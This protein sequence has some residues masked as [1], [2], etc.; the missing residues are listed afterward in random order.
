MQDIGEIVV[1]RKDGTVVE[2]DAK[3]EKWTTRIVN[4]WDQNKEIVMIVVPPAIGLLTLG[5]KTFGKRI[6]LQKEQNLKDRY[7][8][9][10]SLGHYWE[11]KKKLS[12]SQWTEIE[13]RKKTGE[14]LGQILADMN[15]LKGL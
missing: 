3:K 12:N 7:V 5:V 1:V 10:A 8:Y 13:R 4:W 14:C 6:N 15:V 2:D 11:L 9:D